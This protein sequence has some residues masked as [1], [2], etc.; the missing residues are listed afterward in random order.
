M[1]E[2]FGDEEDADARAD[3]RCLALVCSRTTYQDR[4]ASRHTFWGF[5]TVMTHLSR[6]GVVASILTAPLLTDTCRSTVG[7]GTREDIGVTV[8]SFVMVYIA[9]AFASIKL[10]QYRSTAA[11][12]PVEEDSCSWSDRSTCSSG[13]S[14]RASSV[15]VAATTAMMECSAPPLSWRTSWQSVVNLCHQAAWW[16]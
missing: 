14:R 16:L 3:K 13:G 6:H 1:Q 7:P 5:L 9:L 11:P 2:E 4:Q 12:A 10:L 15:V 8:Y